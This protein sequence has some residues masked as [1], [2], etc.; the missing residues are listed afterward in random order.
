[1]P[2]DP[3]KGDHATPLHCPL[4]FDLNVI[5]P[6]L[7][8]L[9]WHPGHALLGFLS[10]LSPGAVPLAGT[11]GLGEMPVFPRGWCGWA[12]GDGQL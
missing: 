1:M 3:T 12:C 7:H 5:H 11:P 4:G 6:L 9:P 2:R 10:W 8:S